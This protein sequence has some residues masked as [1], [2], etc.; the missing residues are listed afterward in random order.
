MLDTYLEGWRRLG[1]KL[2][3]YYCV[4]IESKRIHRLLDCSSRINDNFASARK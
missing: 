1:E 2:I 3:L 4:G